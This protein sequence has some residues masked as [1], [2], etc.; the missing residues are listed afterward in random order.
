MKKK[1]NLSNLEVGKSK[2]GTDNQPLASTSQQLS[3]SLEHKKE[4]VNAIS[5]LS[6][7]GTGNRLEDRGAKSGV[8]TWDQGLKGGRSKKL[9]STDA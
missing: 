9:M 2:E 1:P 7:G 4:E 5:R 3:P 8:M 6:E